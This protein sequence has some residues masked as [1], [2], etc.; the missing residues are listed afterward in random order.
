MT[1]VALILTVALVAAC[2]RSPDPTPAGLYPGETPRMRQLIEEAAS[3][4]DVPAALVHRVVQR[5][6]DYRADARNGPY[7]GLMQMLP[8]TART[9]GHDGP[10]EELL[11]P[12]VNLEYGV[13]YLRGAWLVA[14]GDMDEAVHWYASGYYYEARNR[15]MLVETGLL[16]REIGC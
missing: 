10:P 9:M 14:D 1:R 16:D 7:Y 4:H 12:S 3:R 8:Q 2:G 11:N 13:R 6:S 15:C 5:E